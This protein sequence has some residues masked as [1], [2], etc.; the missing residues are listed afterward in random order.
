M[1]LLRRNSQED[2]SIWKKIQ[3]WILHQ[4]K[5][6][7]DYSEITNVYIPISEIM[8]LIFPQSKA[9]FLEDY[10]IWKSGN[11]RKWQSLPSSLWWTI[12]KKS[13]AKVPF[14]ITRWKKQRTLCWG[15]F[16]WQRFWTIKQFWFKFGYKW[17]EYIVT[18]FGQVI[19]I[20]NESLEK[21][22]CINTVVS[23]NKLIGKDFPRKTTICTRFTKI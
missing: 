18:D 14:N 12:S 10:W 5:K 20:L 16:W 1:P 9:L 13:A 15:A 22:C 23:L 6:S 11:S 21:N 7:I 19:H 3:I 17:T 8:K 4:L 2:K